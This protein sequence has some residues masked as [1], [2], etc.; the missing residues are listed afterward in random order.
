MS[1]RYGVICNYLYNIDISRYFHTSTVLHIIINF[2]D[3]AYPQAKGTIINFNG[4]QSPLRNS[5]SKISTMLKPGLLK[6][7]LILVSICIEDDTF[8]T[9]NQIVKWTDNFKSYPIWNL[10]W[11][12]RLAPLKKINHMNILCILC[13][14]WCHGIF[15]FCFFLPITHIW[16]PKCGYK[17]Y[18]Q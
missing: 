10:E 12:Q 8:T 4:D 3:V 14:K 18:T 6:F 13:S 2:N 11:R 1:Y 17:E 15:N 16:L 7:A 9:Q 5:F